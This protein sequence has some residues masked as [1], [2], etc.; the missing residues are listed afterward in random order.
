MFYPVKSLQL[1]RGSF[2]AHGA[3]G[4]NTPPNICFALARHSTNRVQNVLRSGERQ[5]NVRP[6]RLLVGSPAISLA[7]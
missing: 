4:R 5:R 3:E 7:A 2:N 6:S 1:S